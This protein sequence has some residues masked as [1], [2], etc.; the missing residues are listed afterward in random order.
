MKVLILKMKSIL[1]VILLFA[2]W[3]CGSSENG[4]ETA[5]DNEGTV[6][7]K[8]SP[9]EIG[10]EIKNDINTGDNE[11]RDSGTQKD[12]KS[13]DNKTAESKISD[14][15]F[16]EKK[17]A[18]KTYSLQIAAFND[19]DNAFAF[20]D[21]A[22][23]ILKIQGIYYKNIGG[24]FKIRIGNYNSVEDALAMLNKIYNEGFTDTFVTDITGEKK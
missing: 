9:K 4:I 24:T 11:F 6:E 21:K 19:E 17:T 1:P 12:N 15:K 18:V 20:M 14:N 5:E 7:I 10:G 13:S 2:F 23:Q 8:T 3:G 22:K 16:S